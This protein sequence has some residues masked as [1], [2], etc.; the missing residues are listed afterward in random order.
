MQPSNPNQKAS[1]TMS[2]RALIQQFS[3]TIDSLPAHERALLGELAGRMNALSD[4]EV[5]QAIASG[6]SRG[7]TVRTGVRAGAA[8]GAELVILDE[9]LAA[10]G[11]GQSGARARVCVRAGADADR[12]RASLTLRR[13]V[14]APSE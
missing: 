8:A 5:A 2:I 1:R 12:H 10:V 6:A 4:Q 13:R 3:Q 7:L 9:S 14:E 11:S